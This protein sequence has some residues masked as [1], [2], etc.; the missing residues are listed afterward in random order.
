MMMSLSNLIEVTVWKKL[1]DRRIRTRVEKNLTLLLMLLIHLLS[2][3]SQV[4]DN[5]MQSLPTSGG[6]GESV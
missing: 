2:E 1:A 6:S 5:H 3:M 4:K